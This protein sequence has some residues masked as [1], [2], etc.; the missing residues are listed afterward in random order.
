MTGGGVRLSS[1]LSTS[2]GSTVVVMPVWIVPMVLAFVS[3]AGGG[4]RES[5]TLTDS[6]ICF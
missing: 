1:R 4:N 5:D 2:D 3:F 6:S